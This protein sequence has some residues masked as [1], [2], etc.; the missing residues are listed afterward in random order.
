M[1]NTQALTIQNALAM[2]T[3]SMVT[4]EAVR[5]EGKMNGAPFSCMGIV[6]SIVRESGGG[7]SY[8]IETADKYSVFVKF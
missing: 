8:I 7:R 3:M 6:N 2:Y 4:G 5:V 1:S